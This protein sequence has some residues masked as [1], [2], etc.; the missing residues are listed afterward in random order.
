MYEVMITAGFP[1]AHSLRKYGGKCENLHGHNFRVDVHARA[2]ELNSTGLAIDFR[3][4][5]EKTQVI[6]NQLDHKYLND[7]PYF[8]KTNP[9]SENIAVYIFK[10]LKKE[11]NDEN[12][13]ITKVAV[14]ES[15]TSYASYYEEED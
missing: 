1:A 11:L 9:S 5:K 14:W 12:A 4:L 3:I 10:N 13:V 15:E 2:K 7:H 8:V 6:L